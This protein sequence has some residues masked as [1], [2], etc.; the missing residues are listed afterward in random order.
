MQST[1]SSD[2]VRSSGKSG[3]LLVCRRIRCNNEATSPRYKYRLSSS[4]QHALAFMSRM[5]VALSSDAENDSY[6][7]G[8]EITIKTIAPTQPV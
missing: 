6:P 2:F 4:S 5:C 7:F 8:G 3:L 1:R